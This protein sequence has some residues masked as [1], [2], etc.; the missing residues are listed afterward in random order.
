MQCFPVLE[1]L[2]RKSTSKSS[3]CLNK[4]TTNRET[5]LSLNNQ[6]I[7]CGSE[8]NYGKS[9]LSHAAFI[10]S[11]LSF[12]QQGFITIFQCLYTAVIS[13]VN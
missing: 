4:R 3:L 1:K 9:F 6:L 2:F 8:L 13:A 12:R 5:K 10:N 7:A 11:F